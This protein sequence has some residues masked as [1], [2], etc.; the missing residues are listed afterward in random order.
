VNV[1]EA[2]IKA[3]RDGRHG[4]TPRRASRPEGG[5][6]EVPD[7]HP[8]DS[9]EPSDCVVAAG[10]KPF[11]GYTILTVTDHGAGEEVIYPNPGFPIYESYIRAAGAVPVPLPLREART[12]GSISTTCAGR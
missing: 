9:V 6:G 3:I 12:S 5:G 4:Y 2:G 7:R 8:R 1:Q 10:A 11:I